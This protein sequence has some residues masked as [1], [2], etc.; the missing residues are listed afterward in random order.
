MLRWVFLFAALPALVLVP[1][2]DKETIF[3]TTQAT[4]WLEI[5][6][7]LLCPTFIAYFLVQPAIKRIGSELVSIYQYLVPVF[8]TITAVLMRLDK[9][10]WIQVIAMIVI[11]AGMVLTD[12]GKRKRVKKENLK[13]NHIGTLA[14]NKKN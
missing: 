2:M 8:A 14:N 11:V 13:K 6:F 5:G 3:H 7:I 4:P 9:L 12:I 1:G 10:H